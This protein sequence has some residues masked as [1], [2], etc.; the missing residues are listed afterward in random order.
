MILW[1]VVSSASFAVIWKKWHPKIPGC[2]YDVN[3]VHRGIIK[4]ILPLR[5]SHTTRFSQRFFW[6]NLFPYMKLFKKSLQL[7][8][9]VVVCTDDNYFFCSFSCSVRGP[10]CYIMT[11]NDTFIFKVDIH[12]YSCNLVNILWYS[13]LHFLF[14]NIFH[15]RY[16]LSF[17]VPY[18]SFF[19]FQVVVFSLT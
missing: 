7:W 9:K 19:I 4:F 8:K 14:W 16:L 18:P 3:V 15:G 12:G 13:V 1:I 17:F 2:K 6:K 10:L 5:P 11:R